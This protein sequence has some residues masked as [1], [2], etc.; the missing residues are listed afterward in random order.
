MNRQEKSSVI[1]SLKD[2]FSQGQGS[3]VVGYKGLTVSQLQILRRGI[4]QNGG[5]FKVTKARLMRLAAQDA[6]NA[7]EL[8]P[9]FKDQIGVVFTNDQ[10]TAVLKFLH[11][12]AKEN[13]A[14]KVVAGSLESRLFDKATLARLASLPS[15]EVLLAQLCGTLKAPI[16]KLAYVLQ[17]VGNKKA[18]VS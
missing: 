10:S 1:S 9:F 12:F 11:T 2:Q 7:Q 6:S 14:L 3:I 18:T 5:S 8:V 17:E 15:R 4:R 16:S 13:E